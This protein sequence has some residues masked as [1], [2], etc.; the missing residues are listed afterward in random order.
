MT[1]D[2]LVAIVEGYEGIKITN[3]GLSKGETGFGRRVSSK[4]SIFLEAARLT[5]KRCS[6]DTVTTNISTVELPHAH[7]M[8]PQC[9]DIEAHNKDMQTHNK[10]MQAHFKDMKAHLC[11]KKDMQSPNKDIEA[12]YKDMTA[13]L[14]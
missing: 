9:K 14:C 4:E 1:L 8:F 6:V 10:D 2:Q 5:R 12:H 13:H 3:W 11:Y 7:N